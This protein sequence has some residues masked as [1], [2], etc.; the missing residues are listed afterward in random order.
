MSRARPPIG[1]RLAGRITLAYV[2]LIVA[3]AASLGIYLTLTLR[4]AQLSQLQERLA[5]EARLIAVAA[6]PALQARDGERA[7]ALARV[8]APA[9]R[10]RVTLIAA[11]G[12]VLGD[13]EAS[14]PEMENHANRP[15]VADALAGATLGTSA[16]HSASVD[17]DLVYV[18]VPV[19]VDD[20][21]IGVARVARDLAGV[22]AEVGRMLVTVLVALA[23][24]VL[25]AALLAGFIARRI[26]E[27]IARLTGAARA[28]APDGLAHPAPPTGDG[29]GEDEIGELGRA[30]DE[31]AAR[32]RDVIENLST[33]RG[34][35]SAVL[36]AMDDGVALVDREERVIL[37]NR[38][39]V[40]LLAIGPAAV[41]ETDP[42]TGTL[43]EPR[44]LIELAPD[45]ELHELT[46]Q[47]VQKRRMRRELVRLSPSGRHLRITATPMRGGGAA[48]LLLVQDVTEVRRAETIRRDFAANV[49]HELK[50][51]IASLKA[52]VETLEDGALDDPP[53]AREFLGRMHV[54]VDGLAQLVQELLDLARIESGQTRM[55]FEPHDVADLL[56]SADRLR[57]QADR[58]GVAFEVTSD[59][60]LPPVRADAARVESALINLVHNAIKFTPPGGG[61]AVRAARDEIDGQPCVRLSVTDTGVGIPEADLPRL[62]ERFYKADKSRA[63]SGT[64]LGLAIVKHIVQAHGGQVGAESEVGKGSTFWFTLGLAER[65][66]AVPAGVHG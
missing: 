17:R 37:M 10:A 18:G 66:S 50:T 52:L 4:A 42:E 40:D 49:S 25:V 23:G 46:R 34:R 32:L 33:D 5:G 38:A 6:A 35:L 2:L 1:R 16:R 11:D 47:A 26:T 15:E 62:F 36:A 28:I 44:R 43:V 13:S 31:M 59:P 61:I 30:F 21:T 12:V 7:N 9:I 55:T 45:H 29:R 64:G 8:L 60:D 57:P 54:E 20:R 22:E 63:S 3:L 48:V 53:A 58:A 24:A 19:R 41:G 56:R 14:P 39:A 65:P 51:P 27:P